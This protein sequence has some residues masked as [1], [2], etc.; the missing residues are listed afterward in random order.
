MGMQTHTP[1][2]EGGSAF[3]DGTS[4]CSAEYEGAG[5]SDTAGT[6]PS[7]CM[8]GLSCLGLQLLLPGT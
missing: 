2:S 8:R 7:P 5:A 3:H 1:A 6:K 4:R